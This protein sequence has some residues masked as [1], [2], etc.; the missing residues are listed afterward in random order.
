MKSYRPL[1]QVVSRVAA[2]GAMF[3]AGTAFMAPGA[4]AAQTPS[5]QPYVDCVVV[6]TDGSFAALFGYKLSGTKGPV[7]IPA[8]YWSPQ[9]A[10]YVNPGTNGDAGQPTSFQ[11][12]DHKG[13][14]QSANVPAG[15]S[16]TWSMSLPGGQTMSATATNQ[17]N[18]CSPSVGLSSAG[19]GLGGPIVLVI[20]GAGASAALAFGAR[21]KMRAKSPVAL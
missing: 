2:I 19:N 11:P 4:G 14:W 8:G 16:V 15:W 3:A 7:Q 9:G 5:I 20:S 10:N 17:S 12:G 21:R 6:N 18:R 13:A 1:F